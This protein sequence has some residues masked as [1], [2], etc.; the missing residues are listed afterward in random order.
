MAA[1]PPQIS[2]AADGQTF[3]DKVRPLNSIVKS[4]FRFSE[5]NIALSAH[6]SLLLLNW[7]FALRFLQRLRSR[8][9]IMA[10][11]AN[12][13]KRKDLHFAFPCEIFSYFFY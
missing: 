12:L 5:K 13:D 1:A 6:S 8:I 7:L 11:V 9:T 4:F 3:F 2:D 10:F